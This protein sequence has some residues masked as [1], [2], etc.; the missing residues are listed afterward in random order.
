MEG[1]NPRFA[2]LQGRSFTISASCPLVL[3]LYLNVGIQ[4][5]TNVGLKHK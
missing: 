5:R 3:D 1:P 2:T 4:E